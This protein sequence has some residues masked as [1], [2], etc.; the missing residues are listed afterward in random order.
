LG[1][2]SLAKYR[3]KIA[4]IKALGWYVVAL[5]GVAVVTASIAALS[6]HIDPSR[7]Q[8]AYLLIV[9]GLAVVGGSGPA[10][11]ASIAAF[12]AYDWFFVSPVG[13]LNVGHAQEWFALG[14]FLTVGV[15][16]GSLAA[17]LKR[18]AER[19]DARTREM[20]TL[21]ELGSA[22]LAA[23]TLQSMLSLVA[24]RL[25][26]ALPLRAVEIRMQ[27]GED[28]VQL[29]ALSTTTPELRRETEPGSGPDHPSVT[30]PLL[31]NDRRLGLLTAY[32]NYELWP[33][34]A[35]G[36]R[37]INAF[38]AE[39]ALAAGRMLLIEE[40]RRAESAEES[41][42]L[43][44]QFIASISHDLRTPITTI[45]T[46]VA[47]LGDS[48]DYATIVDATANVDREADRLSRLVGELLEISRIE[49]GGLRLSLQ[50]EDLE[51]IAGSC[52]RAIEPAL[53]GRSLTL[54]SEGNLPLV[55]VDAPQIARVL[56]NLLENAVKFSPL[57]ATIELRLQNGDNEVDL[58][59]GNEGEPIAAAEQVHIFE[60]FYR[61]ANRSDGR[62]GIGL[63]L[64]ICKGIVEAHRGRIWTAN[65][66]GGVVF[67]VAL[68]IKSGRTQLEVL[69]QI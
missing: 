30:V 66:P 16:A 41:N 21:F 2:G 23:S 64:A 67:H 19:A 7:L 29:M 33:L 52:V 35:S 38:A 63:G 57:G 61:A 24:D 69:T 58:A 53:V 26:T 28:G 1:N 12:L 46:A 18:S 4:H 50:A 44:S 49:A 60:K 51:E 13:T 10:I 36:Q 56:T 42:R 47:S 34:D 65:I 37:L 39:T 15:T 3:L 8:M 48:P 14:L 43:K 54:K 6:P 27:F 68:P 5:V 9:L 45:K 22:L 40:Q 62:E 59:V 17:G 32:G 20:T 55:W 11:A 31:L 25:S